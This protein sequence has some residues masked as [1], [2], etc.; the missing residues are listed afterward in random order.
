MEIKQ[1][2]VDAFAS[3]LFKGNPAA[4]CPLESWLADG[5]M[6]AIAA[7]NNLSETAF[8][9]PAGNGFELRWFTP[10][11]EVDLCGHATLATAHVLYNHLGYEHP[12]IVFSTRSGDLRVARSGDG[13]TMDFPARRTKL[14]VMQDALEKALGKKPKALYSADDYMAVFSS[15][16]EVRALQPDMAALR[17]LDL[18]GVIATAPGDDVDFVSRFFAPGAGIPEDPVTGSAHCTLTP[19]WSRQLGKSRLSARQI[20]ARGGDLLCELRDD[21]VFISGTATTFLEGVIHLPDE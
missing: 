14:C 5:L 16:A 7:E 13:L 18:R 11:K 21:R 10:V 1:F 3:T 19:F 6:Q 8:F 4:V 9:V 12:R 17:G 20:S 15:E 2:Q